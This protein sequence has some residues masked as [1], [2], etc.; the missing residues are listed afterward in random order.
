[1]AAL[2]TEINVPVVVKIPTS[3][4]EDPNVAAVEALSKAIEEP[5]ST[6]LY[7][8]YLV[9]KYNGH[10]YGDWRTKDDIQKEIE[11][12]RMV[13]SGF[14]YM[15]FEEQRM[16]FH[17]FVDVLDTRDEIFDYFKQKCYSKE[18]FVEEID[19]IDKFTRFGQEE[20]RKMSQEYA[21]VTLTTAHSSKGLEWEY[22]FASIS[23]YDNK[24]INKKK[25]DDPEVEEI[26]RLEFVAFTRAKDHLMVTSTYEAWNEPKK[27]PESGK[28]IGRDI[29]YN[30]FLQ[31]LMENEDMEYIPVD[32]NE[33]LREKHKAAVSKANAKKAAEKRKANAEKKDKVKMARLLAK[34]ETGHILTL[35]EQDTLAKL[36]KKYNK[37]K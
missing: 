16:Q 29:G 36:Q 20:E 10:L 37:K 33:A 6:E 28:T 14:S 24:V 13:F 32:P 27:D 19:F 2:L 9:A 5:G 31:E 22:V 18:D 34:K 30:R 26:R 25:A 12:M 23:D 7:L 21:G 11:E 4:A 35:V 17:K 8:Q 3:V 1:M 15:G